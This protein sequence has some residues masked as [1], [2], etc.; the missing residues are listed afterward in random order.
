MKKIVSLAAVLVLAMALLLSGCG[1]GGE[2]ATPSAAADATP[3]A[4]EAAPANAQA[5]TS[6][7]DV[8]S[9]GKLV[10]GLDDAFP[11]MGFRDDSNEI[12]GF[13]IDL[14]KEVASRMGVEL[15]IKPIVWDSMLQ[16]VESGKIDVVWN[17]LSVTTERQE[18]LNLSEPYMKNTQ[19]IVVQ[20]GSDIKTKA[21]LAGKVVG[22][23]DNSSANQAI[24]K[25]EG[26]KDSFKE[27]RGFETN[28]LALLDLAS[29]RLDAVVVDVIVAGYYQTQKPDT[30]VIL[31]ENFG[32]EDFVI[33]FKKG[34]DA[35]T[36]EVQ[37]QLDAMI[38]D[39]TF[40]TISEKW[41]DRDVSEK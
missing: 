23:Q 10:L 7:E 30:Y 6:L 9:A 22:V 39:G 12:V 19:V 3:K 17:G 26:V 34:S 40:K 4:S 31:D 1:N 28:D 11:P 24:E 35:L 13:D 16:E 38:E 21:D 8:K 29:G 27:L 25:D 33:G 36:A 41:F 5:D 32:E 15:E 18:K 20:E 14:A 2:E 37:K